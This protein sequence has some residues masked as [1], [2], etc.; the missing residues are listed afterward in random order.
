MIALLVI[1]FYLGVIFGIVCT[2]AWFSRQDM[3]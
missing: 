3:D 2:F 1:A